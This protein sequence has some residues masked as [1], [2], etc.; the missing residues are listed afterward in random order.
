MIPLVAVYHATNSAT[1]TFFL[2]ES[3]MLRF[4]QF[5]VMFSASLILL[6]LRIIKILLIYTV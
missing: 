5:G 3:V 2:Y 1:N 4:V 6:L